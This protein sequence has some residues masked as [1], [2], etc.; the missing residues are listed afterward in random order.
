MLV[1][2]IDQWVYSSLSSLC[3]GRVY[4]GMAPGDASPPFLVF[5][6]EA[7]QPEYQTGAVEVLQ[8]VHV[9]VKVI[10]EGFTWSD[11]TSIADQ[12]N[13]ALHGKSVETSTY[14]I[15]ATKR[16]SLIKYHEFIDGVRYNHLGG[17]YTIYIQDK[18]SS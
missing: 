3:E 11:I 1:S 15:L 14:R 13:V 10:S 8:R 5:A 12:M 7:A 9:V 2:D 17:Q 16:N 4:E 18:S 6:V